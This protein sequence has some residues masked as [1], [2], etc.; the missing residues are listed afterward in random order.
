MIPRT[1]PFVRLATLD[2][3]SVTE[4]RERCNEC[5]FSAAPPL[6]S[7]VRP[8]A[9]SP[10]AVVERPT[11]SAISESVKPVSFKSL[12][13]DFQVL[14]MTPIV[15]EPGRK[16][17]RESVIRGHIPRQ[18]VNRAPDTSGMRYQIDG[19]QIPKFATLGERV[20]WWRGL[21]G[22]S[23]AKLAQLAGIPAS[24]LSDI[25]RDRQGSSGQIFDLA[26][27]L[28]LNAKY[29]ATDE[30]D[31]LADNPQEEAAYW[32]F[33]DVEAADVQE[34]SAVEL[35]LLSFQ[36]KKAIEEIK[37]LRH[38]KKRRQSVHVEKPA[39]KRNTSG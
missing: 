32:P 3:K 36:V 26:R 7:D 8:V 15:R 14:S 20:R 1:H 4:H 18:P 6:G 35:K 11:S 29:L 23:Q 17:Q 33:E 16:K 24:T 38:P 37:Q 2:G 12:T 27:I 39:A 31:P 34:L 22:L 9:M 19:K 10:S 13:R 28:R 25:E 30:G 5:S 21:R